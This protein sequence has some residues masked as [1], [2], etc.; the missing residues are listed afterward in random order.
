M[1]SYSDFDF[2][3]FHIGQGH[4]KTFCNKTHLYQL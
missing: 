2:E 1:Q 3:I 4:D